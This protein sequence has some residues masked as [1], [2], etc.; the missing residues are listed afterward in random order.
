[1]LSGL[2]VENRGKM[3][4]DQVTEWS[5]DWVAKLLGD[6]YRDQMTEWPSDQVTEWLSDSVTKWTSDQ[7]N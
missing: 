2:N 4:C 1:M 5:S 7:L 6:K 3:T